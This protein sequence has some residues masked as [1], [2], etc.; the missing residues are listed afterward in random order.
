MRAG[1]LTRIAGRNVVRLF[2]NPAIGAK[3]LRALSLTAMAAAL[4]D[5]HQNADLTGPQL[6]RVPRAPRRSR[7]RVARE[8]QSAIGPGS[9]L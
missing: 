8:R 2:Q 6:R 3:E 5:Q 4:S 9:S 1:R 7:L